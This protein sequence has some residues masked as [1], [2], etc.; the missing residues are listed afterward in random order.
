MMQRRPLPIGNCDE[1]ISL[2]CNVVVSAAVV[3]FKETSEMTTQYFY[4][5]LARDDTFGEVSNLKIEYKLCFIFR[6]TKCLS[7]TF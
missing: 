1:V 3:I 7:F 2:L 5:K 6:S 4:R